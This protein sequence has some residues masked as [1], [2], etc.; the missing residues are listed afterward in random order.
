M[1]KGSGVTQA[2]YRRPSLSLRKVAW[3]TG[4]PRAEGSA[5]SRGPSVGQ[6]IL[7]SKQSTGL[8]AEG[9]EGQGTWQLDFVFGLESP[10][11]SIRVQ[12]APWEG[13]FPVKVELR[14]PCLVTLASDRGWPR[15]LP[16]ES[17]APGGRGVTG[18][19]G[20]SREG[21]PGLESICTWSRV[22]PL[23]LK[24][25]SLGNDVPTQHR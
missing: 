18:H 8:A 7:P 1:G 5:G 21:V 22:K 25:E 2:T 10:M 15:A 17:E 23:F 6:P 19:L 20:C 3:D 12:G 9:R 14:A 16:R 24:P 11:R 4:T 13:K